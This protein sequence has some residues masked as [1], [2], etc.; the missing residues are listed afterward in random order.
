MRG[1]GARSGTLLE[2]S[3]AVF[4]DLGDSRG[5]AEVLLEQGR[6]AHAQG[7]DTHAASLCRQSLALSSKLDNKT[8]IAFCLTVLAGATRANG[9]PARAARLFGAAQTLLESQNAVLDPAG[10]LEYENN[11]T[12]TRA[13]LLEDAFK[14]EWQRG[15]TMTLEQAIKEATNDS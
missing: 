10:T 4:E 5:V 8:H 1:E 13:Q 6:V 9:D 15:T 3:L 2:E 11:L 12:A 14:K 7:D